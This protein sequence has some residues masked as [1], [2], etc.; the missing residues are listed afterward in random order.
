MR[1]RAFLGRLAGIALAP[2]AG[3]SLDP[4][5]PGCIAGEQQAPLISMTEIEWR[6]LLSEN[7]YVV[8]FEEGT[9]LPWSSSLDQE[10]RDGTYLCAACLIPLFLSRTK[11]ESGTGWP[12][13]WEPIESR[14]GFKTD[15]ELPEPRTAYYCLRCGGH[16]GHVFDDGPPPTGQRYCNNGVALSFVPDGLQ[17]P[18]PRS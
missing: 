4:T 13:F 8:L 9:E 12:S 7:A 1:R 10:H 15:C 18:T 16:Q 11:Y 3:C 2:V 6:A 14:L 17:L 5:G